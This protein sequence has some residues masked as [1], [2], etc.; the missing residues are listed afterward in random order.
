MSRSA[1][2][3]HFCRMFGRS[4]MSLLREVRLRRASELLATTRLPVEAVARSVGFSSRSN[5][6]RMFREMYG[7]DP[8]GFRAGSANARVDQRHAPVRG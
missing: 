2:A 4:P 6:S 3:A 1:F 7:V 8:S 5:F